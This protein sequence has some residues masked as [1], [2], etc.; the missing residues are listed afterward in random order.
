M[1]DDIHF[2][3]LPV[4]EISTKRKYGKI[5]CNP[6][7]ESGSV[8]GTTLPSCIRKWQRLSASLIPG[9]TTSSP[10]TQ[11]SRSCLASQ[12][13]SGANL[14][15]PYGSPVLPVLR[16]PAAPGSIVQQ[17]KCFVGN[18]KCRIVLSIRHLFFQRCGVTD[19]EAAL[20]CSLVGLHVLLYA[21]S[22]QSTDVTIPVI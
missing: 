9:P 5:I 15:R 12:L 14:Q 22:L 2:Q 19:L 20:I 17:S 1:S 4:S 21:H 3:C 10:P 11:H 18:A 13:P 8:N 7:M 16:P 6:H